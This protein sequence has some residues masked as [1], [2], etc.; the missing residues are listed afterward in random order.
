MVGI[1][2]VSYV[3]RSKQNNKIKII[4]VGLILFLEFS[5]HAIRDLY[6]WNYIII[7]VVKYNKLFCLCKGCSYF[8]HF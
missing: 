6:L 3:Y 7:C 1:S 4:I 8:G 2:M 5:E